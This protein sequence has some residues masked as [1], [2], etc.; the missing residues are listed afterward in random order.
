M[1]SHGIELARIRQRPQLLRMYE[2]A[3]EEGAALIEPAI[4]YDFRAVTAVRHST[5][6][7]DDGRVINSSLVAGL[8]ASASEIGVF[9][10][11]IGAKLE[12]RISAYFAENKPT[13]AVVLDAVGVAA[14]DKLVEVCQQIAEHEAARQGLKASIPLSPG[15]SELCSLDEQRLIFDLL[16]AANIGVSLTSG[17]MMVP[18][19]SASMIIGLGNDVLTKEMG[20]QCDFCSARDTCRQRKTRTLPTED[21][22]S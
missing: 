8:L 13:R 6:V 11:T 9:L 16:P 1:R 14:V 4:A 5:L 3:M 2:E 12:T 15:M 22:A 18:V 20:S 10:A 7:L 19:K 17:T 21:A